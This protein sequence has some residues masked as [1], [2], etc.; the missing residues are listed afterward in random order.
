M[1][2]YLSMPNS[3]ARFL[4]RAIV[5]ALATV[6]YLPT[7]G[8]G[9]VFDDM[10]LVVRNPFLREPWTFIVAFARHFWYGTQFEAG[11]YRPI[12]VA[13][14]ALNGSLLG[15][16]AAGFHL[17]NVL[18]HAANAVL[19]IVL[20]R[21]LGVPE[22]AS[23]IAAAF[24]AIHPVAAWPVASVVARV[25]LLPAFFVLLAWCCHASPRPGKR[26]ALL[27]GL[28]FLAALACKESAIAFLAVPLLTWLRPPVGPAG[29][30][31]SQRARRLGACSLALGLYCVMRRAAGVPFQL[32][33]N[34]IDPVI[35]PLAHVP[36]PG[37]LYAALRLSGRYLLYL[38]VPTRFSDGADYNPA[39][40]T[41]FGPWQ[42][43]VLFGL[44]VVIVLGF[45][46]LEL[47]RRR[48][49]VAVP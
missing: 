37:R 16:D 1:L 43:G 32:G 41:V 29:E 42:P 35:N 31:G 5:A 22:R 26:S 28:F 25:D 38:L 27:T 40:T 9:F 24:F 4:P 18:L 11:Y 13:S 34:L 39:S 46:I 3:R 30:S 19:V 45:A 20:A 48:R 44:G 47:R 33:R 7:L 15:W 2:F 8:F 12:V 10:Y 21:R 36:F 23:W 49:P 14:F 6:P 17:V